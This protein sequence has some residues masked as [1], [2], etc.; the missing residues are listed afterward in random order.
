MQTQLLFLPWILP[1]ATSSPRFFLPSLSPPLGG[2]ASYYLEL[3]IVLEPFDDTL[4]HEP[5]DALADVPGSNSTDFPDRTS[6]DVAEM[7]GR[8]GTSPLYSSVFP[9]HSTRDAVTQNLK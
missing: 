8:E 7:A 4:V 2:V 5:T 3:A 9:Q 6:Q 1:P